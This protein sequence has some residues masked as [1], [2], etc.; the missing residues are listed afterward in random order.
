MQLEDAYR[1]LKKDRNMNQSKKN[2]MFQIRNILFYGGLTKEQYKRV[3]NTVR[4]R[5]QQ[6]FRLLCILAIFIMTLMFIGSFIFPTLSCNRFL[7]M[8]YAFL[9][10]LSLILLSLAHNTPFVT[11]A[12]YID[13]I[14]GFFY[15]L[16]LAFVSKVAVDSPAV[17]FVAS[18]AILPLM[19]TDVLWRMMI[20]ILGAGTSFLYLSHMFSSPATFSINIANT[21]SMSLIGIVLYTIN[22]LQNYRRFAMEDHVKSEHETEMVRT[23]EF[24]N[25][26]ADIIESRDEDTGDHVQRTST[27]IDQ[28]MAYIQTHGD[29]GDLK[30]KPYLDQITPKFRKNVTNA[31]CL[32]DIGKIRISDTI[33]NKPGKLTPDEFETMKLH[34]VYGGEMVNKILG[35]LNV[36][37]YQKIAYNIARHHHERWDG[38]GYPD[39]LKGTEIPLEARLMSLVDVYDALTH[40]RCYKKAYSKEKAL[41]IIK[42]G[43]GTQFDPVLGEAFLKEKMSEKDIPADQ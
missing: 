13:L 25:S 21:I 36:P 34:T 4:E 32:H 11:V 9:C 6:V 16:I 12:C 27:E 42:E 15:G 28:L 24:I 14:I 3:H 1:L 17:T 7:Y 2:P 35:K 41:Q 8:E 33:L 40:D 30:E 19:M 10:V 18:L 39:K 37:Y 22:S 5:N 20:L 38:T 29:K 43:I 31:A 23:Q 26:L